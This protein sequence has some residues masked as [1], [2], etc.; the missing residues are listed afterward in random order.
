MNFSHP[1]ISSTEVCF[2]RSRTLTLY[3]ADTQ[4]HLSPLSQGVLPASG[5]LRY[6]GTFNLHVQ[7]KKKK[8]ANKQ[9][10]IRLQVGKVQNK[11]IQKETHI[12]APSF[13]ISLP[14]PSPLESQAGSPPCPSSCL[15]GNYFSTCA[16]PSWLCSHPL[17]MYL[18]HEELKR[19][20]VSSTGH[21][22]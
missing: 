17:N 15:L 2:F 13:W 10:I 16:F 3:T 21:G 7:L 22:G 11:Q 14:A 6:L 20:D 8:K 9:R 12:I 5:Y 18:K 1:Y 4:T 19:G